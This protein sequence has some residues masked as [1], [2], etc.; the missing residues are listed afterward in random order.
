MPKKLDRCVEKVKR[1]GSKVNPYAVCKA[2]I[3]RWEKIK[4]TKY[5]VVYRHKKTKKLL[6]L[7]SIR[8]DCVDRVSFWMLSVGG[9]VSRKV[10]GETNTKVKAI[11]LA[12]KYMRKH[13]NG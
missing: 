2:S 3:S 12:K 13:K 9:Q 5:E 1:S 4:D 7:E 10:V 11:K 8:C 6:K